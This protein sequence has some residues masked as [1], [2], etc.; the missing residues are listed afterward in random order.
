MAVIDY[1]NDYAKKIKA[2]GICFY[3]SFIKFKENPNKRAP[4]YNLLLAFFCVFAFF[5]PDYVLKISGA[6]N[7]AFDPVFWLVFF[8]LG[9]V[10]SSIKNK[11]VVLF[12]VGMFFVFELIQLHYMA[13]FGRPIAPPEIKKIFTETGD[14][15]ESG[16]KYFFVVWYVL[17]T[18]LLSYG[19]Y[20]YCFLK[21]SDKCLKTNLS[22]ILLVVFLS[23]KPIRAYHKTLKHFL[24]A[25][26]RNSIHNTI[27]TFSYFFVKD[28]WNNASSMKL[29]FQ[30]YNIA[31]VDGFDKPNIVV[32]LVLESANYNHFGLYGYGRDTTPYLS[33]LKNNGNFLFR[34]AVSSSVSTAS[35]LPFLFNVIREPGNLKMLFNGE[36]SL[37]RLARDSG[38]STYFITSQDAKNLNNVGIKYIDV[39]ITKQNSPLNFKLKKD[40]YLLELFE[41]YLDM[42]NDRFI[43]IFQ[44]NLHSPYEYNYEGMGEFDI[45]GSTSKTRRDLAI[46]TYDNAV[47]YED[48][49]IK[50]LIA[51][52]N[53]VK[54]KSVILVITA[55]HGQ[56]FGEDNIYGH[57]V[58][59]YR[60]AEVP[61]MVY[62]NDLYAKS[63]A[64]KNIPENISHYEIGKFVANIMGYS[65]EN[66][67][68]NGI[69]FIHGNN[70]Y[71][72]NFIMPFSRN[73]DGSLKF[74]P[75]SST[76][77]YF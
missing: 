62:Y 10:F 14:I 37:F 58:L 45:Y 33:G 16:A 77:N 55:D 9:L 23:L 35:S 30:N 42:E 61:F 44:R 64:N 71:S 74:Y 25:P 17:P 13:Y 21:F 73:A 56:M 4:L 67:N 2:L 69:F 50:N 66:P 36:N 12:V 6:S 29:S 65:I 19:I 7:V 39:V 63:F 52:I 3:D 40:N 11:K 31:K 53:G 28:L 47:R 5:V 18:M 68:E 46:N 1:I 72:D 54:D 22:Y 49:F 8:L 51:M 24:P 60:V 34:K 75:I 15:V 32:F 57:N 59:D 48:N 70:I 43:A 41:K 38:Y 20:F 27:N 76:V 26:T